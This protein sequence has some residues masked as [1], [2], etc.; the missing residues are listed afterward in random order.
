[1]REGQFRGGLNFVGGSISFRGNS[2][3]CKLWEWELFYQNRND[4]E[5]AIP[6]NVFLDTLLIQQLNWIKITNESLQQKTSICFPPLMFTHTPLTVSHLQKCSVKYT[7]CTVFCYIALLTNYTGSGFQ[8]KK[9]K[10]QIEQPFRSTFMSFLYK[11]ASPS[12]R[13][14]L[15]KD[16]C[17]AF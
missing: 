15:K 1:M 12:A 5:M 13:A 11:S 10:W 3:R 16:F 6:N 8:L 14:P 17:Y 9:A 7:L 4:I 2:V